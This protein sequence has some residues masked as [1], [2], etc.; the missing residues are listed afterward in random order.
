MPR[1]PIEPARMTPHGAYG[2]VRSTP[3][4]GSCGVSSHPCVHRG[5]DIAAPP[6]TLVRAPAAGTVVVVET[7]DEPP[8]RGYGPELVVI[9]D[10]AGAH[11][12]LA[13]LDE[14]TVKVGDVVEEG[15]D[16]GLSGD[17]N[18]VHWEVRDSLQGQKRDPGAWL[19]RGGSLPAGGSSWLLVLGVC[20]MLYELR[21][22]HRSRRT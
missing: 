9:R 2:A 3:A 17:A 1:A 22:P 5:A 16:I 19:A 4:Q 15:E 6:G 7:G 12:L 8:W 10:H 21:G 18:H 11:H 20:W 13:H 14:A